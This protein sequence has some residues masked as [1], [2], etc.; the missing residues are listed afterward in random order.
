MT[1]KRPIDVRQRRAV[2]APSPAPATLTRSVLFGYSFEIRV[3]EV[4]V[5]ARASLALEVGFPRPTGPV[6]DEMDP[7]KITSP[8]R[9]ACLTSPGCRRQSSWSINVPYSHASVLLLPSSELSGL[10]AKVWAFELGSK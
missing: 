1:R 8:S 7:P 4:G 2:D 9:S 3:D 10:L 5:E 6:D